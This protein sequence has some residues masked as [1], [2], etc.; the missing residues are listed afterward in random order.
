MNYYKDKLQSE[1]KKKKKK[2]QYIE[3]DKL[4]WDDQSQDVILTVGTKIISKVTNEKINL[5]NNEQ[6]TISNIDNNNIT[7]QNDRLELK[8]DSNIFQKNFRVAY[9]ITCHC[10]QAMTIREPYM[11]HEWRKMDKKL[12]Y[13]ALSRSSLKELIYIYQ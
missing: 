12:K 4:K 1:A 7:I 6:F 10:S 5:F 9:A 13:V 11:I 2:F 3:L 8:F